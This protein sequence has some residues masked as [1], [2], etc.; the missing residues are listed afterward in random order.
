[1][2]WGLFLIQYEKARPS[3]GLNESERLPCS[4][5]KKGATALFTLPSGQRHWTSS[6]FAMPEYLVALMPS[7]SGVQHDPSYPL[8][9]CLFHVDNI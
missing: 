8:R 9:A 3:S 2:T 1:M 5:A 4:R 7:E 6:W